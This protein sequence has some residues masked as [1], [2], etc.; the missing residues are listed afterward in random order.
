MSD[1]YYIV[2]DGVKCDRKAI[3][4]AEGAV[5][6]AGDGRI[7]LDDAKYLLAA[8]KDA[9][10]YT[11]VEKA[12][13]KYIRE[14][15]RFTEPA[16][17]WFRTEIRRWAA[18]RSAGKAAQSVTPDPQAGVDEPPVVAAPPPQAAE[19]IPPVA[20]PPPQAA[21]EDTPAVTAPP[22]PL[23]PAPEFAARPADSPLLQPS[24]GP[25]RKWIIAAGLGAIALVAVLFLLWRGLATPPAD[26]VAEVGEAA[27]TPAPLGEQ[28][29]TPA[30]LGEQAESSVPVGEQAETPAPVAAAA[31]GE[32]KPAAIAESDSTAAVDTAPVPRTAASAQ[33]APQSPP[34]G[35]HTV[36]AGDSLW[37]IA[38]ERYQDPLIWPNIYRVNTALIAD[39]DRIEPGLNVTVPPLRGTPGELTPEDRTALARG[40]LQAYLAYKKAGKSKAPYYLWM[41]RQQDPAVIKG[42]EGKIDERDLR[43]SLR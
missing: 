19:D 27:K 36:Q 14:N 35:I 38:R 31:K 23:G 24:T 7:S 9:N 6:G 18:T 41:A 26:S 33:A 20:A 15:Y 28:A 13:M 32:E 42:Y 3:E 17:K 30:P 1:D 2:M 5:A 29:E 4:L 43:F 10:L 37:I 34:S 40:Y 8:V 16:D 22:Q 39:P 12:T 21:V 25:A 11:D